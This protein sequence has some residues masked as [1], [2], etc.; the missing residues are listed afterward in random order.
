MGSEERLPTVGVAVELA[1]ERASLGATAFIHRSMRA[2]SFEMPRGQS[3]STAHAS[4]R[5]PPPR[6]KFA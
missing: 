6:R 1:P 5:H 4:H 3:R 2:F